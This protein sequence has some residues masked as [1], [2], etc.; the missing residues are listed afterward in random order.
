MLNNTQF[1][2]KWGFCPG[3]AKNFMTVPTVPS[4]LQAKSVP[5]L[6]SPKRRQDIWV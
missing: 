2:K 5:N 6:I 4:L 1:N 3:Q